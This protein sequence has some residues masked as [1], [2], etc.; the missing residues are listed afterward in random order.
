MKEIFI[1]TRKGLPVTLQYL[2]DDPKGYLY[3][4]QYAGNGHYFRNLKEAENYL[5]KRKFMTKGD[6]KCALFQ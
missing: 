2:P 3:C 4:I 1:C 5:I 6:T